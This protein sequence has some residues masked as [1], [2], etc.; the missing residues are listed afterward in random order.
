MVSCAIAEL[1]GCLLLERTLLVEVVLVVKEAA[2]VAAPRNQV[3][4]EEKLDSQRPEENSLLSLKET[5]IRQGA[6]L[7]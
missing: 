6:V 3:L 7:E 4:E 1:R 2:E 5:T